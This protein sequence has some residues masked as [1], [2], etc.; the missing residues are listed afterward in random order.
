MT[1]QP[2]RYSQKAHASASCQGPRV[3]ADFRKQ[4]WLLCSLLI[5]CET[6][7]QV[8][9]HCLKT[10]VVDNKRRRKEFLQLH[11]VGTNPLALTHI[12]QCKTLFPMIFPVPLDDCRKV[13][14]LLEDLL[15]YVNQISRRR[16]IPL[17]LRQSCNNTWQNN[18][19]SYIYAYIYIWKHKK[20]KEQS[21]AKTIFN[22][23]TQD[24]TT[25]FVWKFHKNAIKNVIK[26]LKPFLK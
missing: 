21:F 8:I 6:K 25:N 2:L 16:R 3:T 18:Q 15:H 20:K 9:N 5:S 24:L 7:R 17:L 19:N 10:L 1:L 26:K 22:A 4:L 12:L 23:H 14:P 11:H 13:V